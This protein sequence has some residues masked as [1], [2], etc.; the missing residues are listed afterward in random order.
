MSRYGVVHQTVCGKVLFLERESE[1]KRDKQE[2]TDESTPSTSEP[3]SSNA[4]KPTRLL[5]K[6][7]PTASRKHIRPNINVRRCLEPN[8]MAKEH[9]DHVDGV[10][11]TYELA[12]SNISNREGLPEHILPAPEL[13][14]IYTNRDVRRLYVTNRSCITAIENRPSSSTC[15]KAVT[16]AKGQ[17]NTTKQV[18]SHMVRPILF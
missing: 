3:S 6:I 15:N 2:K 17:R 14:N 1:R 5:Q 18:Q 9:I 4:S 13:Q 11:R 10:P 8:D 7:L 16:G 12:P